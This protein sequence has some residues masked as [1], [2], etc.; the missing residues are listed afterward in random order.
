M[1]S[2][3]IYCGQFSI[4]K[5]TQS[6]GINEAYV[7]N[8]LKAA[9]SLFE[10][11]Y[12]YGG[13]SLSESSLFSKESDRFI[14]DPSVDYLFKNNDP[15]LYEKFLDLA[16]DHSE[17]ILFIPRLTHPEFLYSELLLRDKPAFSYLYFSIFAFEL[18]SKSRARSLVLQNLIS[19]TPIARACIHSIDINPKSPSYFPIEELVL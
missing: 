7:H 15:R 14:I 12:L 19:L 3:Y 4:R 13:S 10:K 6:H 9:T 11:V 2:L 8:F 17:A 1:K 5:L 18:V 16:I